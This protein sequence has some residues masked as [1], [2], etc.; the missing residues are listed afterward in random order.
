MNRRNKKQKYSHFY[1]DEEIIVSPP[2][3]S[4]NSA[5]K[6]LTIGGLVLASGS[7]VYTGYVLWKRN[8]LPDKIEIPEDKLPKTK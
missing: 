5:L 7:I 8:S 3:A 2:A 1:F 4:N 6:Y